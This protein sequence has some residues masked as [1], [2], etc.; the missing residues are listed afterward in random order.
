[1]PVLFISGISRT[2]ISNAEEI[3]RGFPNAIHLIIDSAVHSDPVPIF[4]KIKDV[5]LEFMKGERVSTT[6][7]TLP[8]RFIM[9]S[10]YG[11][12]RN[13]D[14]PYA[15]APVRLCRLIR[16]RACSTRGTRYSLSYCQ[17]SADARKVPNLQPGLGRY[18]Q[19]MSPT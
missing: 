4:A 16:Y 13:A 17:S 18:S 11:S 3:K 19:I 5:M 10:P 2:P 15:N 8:T 7:I 12:T 9:R 6:R 14:H 1:V